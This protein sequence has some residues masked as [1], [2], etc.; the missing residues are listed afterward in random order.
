MISSG[1]QGGWSCVDFC[2]TA[3]GK[4]EALRFAIE[5]L[6]FAP[7]R[8]LACGDSGNDEAMY[9]CPEC[10]CV[11]VGN[12]LDDLIAALRADAKAGPDAVQSGQ[13][14]ETKSG[15]EVLFAEQFCSGGVLEALHRFWPDLQ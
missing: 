12:A 14:F 6:A 4:L 1:N 10:R 15:S 13:V 9:R 11:A 2:P 5:Q 3:G 8:T 7:K